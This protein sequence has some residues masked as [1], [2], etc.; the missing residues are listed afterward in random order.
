MHY[1][2][3]KDCFYVFTVALWF[4]LM[5]LR[6]CYYLCNCSVIL[7]NKYWKKKIVFINT[8]IS[9]WMLVYFSHKVI[10]IERKLFCFIKY[11]KSSN[12]RNGH[13]NILHVFCPT[14]TK[15][16]KSQITQIWESDVFRLDFIAYSTSIPEFGA[17]TLILLKDIWVKAS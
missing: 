1:A 11:N 17:E 16:S 7:I 9:L 12:G 14:L 15:G 13:W 3:N 4:C 8:A 5:C 2:N 10:L 6:T